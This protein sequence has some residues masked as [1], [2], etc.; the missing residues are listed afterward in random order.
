MLALQT[1]SKRARLGDPFL[2]QLGFGVSAEPAFDVP[3][4]FGM[5]DEEI[6]RVYRTFNAN[7]DAF[8]AESERHGAQNDHD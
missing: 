2:G 4:G 5:T 8:R 1:E 7:A 6:L 3:V